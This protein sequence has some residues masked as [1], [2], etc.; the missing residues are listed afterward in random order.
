VDEKPRYIAANCVSAVSSSNDR[1]LGLGRQ[2]VAHLRHLRLDLVSAAL[3][4]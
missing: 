3:V 1:R 4:S 2:V